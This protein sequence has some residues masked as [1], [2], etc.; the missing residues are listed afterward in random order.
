MKTEFFSRQQLETMATAELIGIA[1]KYGID[2]PDDLSRRFIIGELLEAEEEARS[3]SPHKEDVRILNEEE[4]VPDS[5]PKTYNNTAIDAVPRNPA[6]LFVF[7]DVKE[8]ETALL[9]QNSSFE[10]SFLHVSF[11]ESAKDENPSD[12]FD[13]KVSL[14]PNEQYI[15]IPGGKKFVRVDLSVSIK[16]NVSVALASTRLIEIPSENESVQNVPPGKKTAF[17]PLVQLSGM[18]RI[19]HDHFISHRQSFSD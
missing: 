4:P 5:L 19:L 9:L 13:I 11:F 3:S 15:M 1:D 2:I 18:R 10:S 8:A 16:G 12:S 14:E 6:W 17:P 7:W